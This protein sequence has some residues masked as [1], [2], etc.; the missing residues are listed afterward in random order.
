MTVPD[1]EEARFPVSVLGEDE[2][3]F[4]VSVLGEEALRI[5][6]LPL[7][8]W[9]V[10]G[11][12]EVPRLLS[13]G[14]VLRGFVLCGFALGGLVFCC[15]VSRGFVL[16]GFVLR[17]AGVRFDEALSTFFVSAR[18][19]FSPDLG[20]LPGFSLVAVSDLSGSRKVERRSLVTLATRAAPAAEAGLPDDRVCC[21]F[22]LEGIG[23]Y[24]GVRSRG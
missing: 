13:C 20:D 23:L 10:P 17:G 18:F 9:R 5:G 15:F 3:R 12:S 2:V 19:F 16:R 11:L 24:N 6:F 1:G 14:F 21:R 7:G 22:G 4:P 8:R